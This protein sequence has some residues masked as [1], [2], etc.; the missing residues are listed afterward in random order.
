[1]ME[2]DVGPIWRD[3]TAEFEVG[4]GFWVEVLEV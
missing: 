1:M 3:Q 4:V 2:A